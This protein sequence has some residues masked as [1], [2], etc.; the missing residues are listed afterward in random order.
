MKILAK[1]LCFT[2]KEIEAQG[3]WT[4]SPKLK[5]RQEKKKKQAEKGL[6]SCLTTKGGI[7]FI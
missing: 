1:L 2:Y 6:K 5:S 7:C 3:L 4:T